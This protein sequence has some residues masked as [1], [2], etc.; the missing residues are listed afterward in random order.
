MHLAGSPPITILALMGTQ[1]AHSYAT[2]RR[3]RARVH[4]SGRLAV[5][6]RTHP[7]THASNQATN[8]RA[9]ATIERPAG[10]RGSGQ[11]GG[12]KKLNEEKAV[13]AGVT[14]AQH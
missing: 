4:G 11:Q 8:A 1:L 13:H 6:A 2:V 7:C 14:L 12:A 10:P 3:S 5:A 9:T